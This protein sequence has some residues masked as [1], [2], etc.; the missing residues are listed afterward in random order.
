M[1]DAIVY[2]PY[3]TQIWPLFFTV[4]V[5]MLAFVGTGYSLL[6]SGITALCLIGIGIV[7]VW[8][9]KVL[10]DSSK[11][12]IFFEQKGLRII[13]G[14]HLDYRYIPWER[15]SYGGYAKNYKGHLFL[16]LSP[17]ALS[18]KE[19]KHFANQVAN[20]SRI[21]IDDVVVIY[22]DILQDVSKIKELIESHIEQVDT[23]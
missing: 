14:S 7:C 10:Y 13:G 20:S 4:P 1:N 12:A 6:F 23:F 22:L 17:N 11:R 3:K 2:R 5:G 15:L 19:A 8:L 16:V 9:T 18:S 21:F